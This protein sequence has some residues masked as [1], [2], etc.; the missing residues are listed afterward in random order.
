MGTANRCSLHELKALSS[1]KRRH[2]RVRRARRGE[3]KKTPLAPLRLLALWACT[4]VRLGGI[5]GMCQPPQA[6][7]WLGTY[8]DELLHE[9]EVMLACKNQH[10]M[11]H[12]HKF[13]GLGKRSTL[14][15]YCIKYTSVIRQYSIL[16][17]TKSPAALST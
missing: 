9:L 1:R 3:E 16:P 7:L 13:G 14:V 11:R 4:R 8:S 10:L 15:F 17:K 5:T 2:N 12:L 6:K